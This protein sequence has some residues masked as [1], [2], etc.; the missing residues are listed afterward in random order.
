MRIPSPATVANTITGGA[1]N[2]TL[3]RTRRQRHLPSSPTNFGVDTLSD[4][5]GLDT[6]D[7]SAVTTNLTFNINSANLSITDG[8]NS[9]THSGAAFDTFIGGGGNDTFNIGSGVSLSGTIDGRSGA[10]TLSLAGI[11]TTRNVSLTALGSLA[12]FN[13]TDASVP[14]GFF[15]ISTLVGGTGNDSLNGLNAISS[16]Q[17]SVNSNQYVSTNTLT[18]SAFENLIGGSDADT[19]TLTA[20]QT[21]HLIRQTVAPTR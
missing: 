6:L 9:I 11:N 21:H 8:T 20:S 17:L 14:N 2:D 18:F 13:G 16:W 12:G 3:N 19:F 5:S 15:N 10:N 7:F 1:G 4:T